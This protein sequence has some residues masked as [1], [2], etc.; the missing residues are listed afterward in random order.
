[1]AGHVARDQDHLY[2]LSGGG[3]MGAMAREYDW[4]RSPVG[5]PEQWPPSL[6]TTLSILFASRYPMFLW[7]GKELIQFYNDPYR[8]SLGELRHPAA[9]GQRGEECWTDIWNFIEPQIERVREGEST[10]SE[11]QLVPILRNGRMEEVFWTYSHS[12]VRVE[13]GEVEGILVVLTETTGQVLADRRM[14]SLAQLAAATRGAHSETEACEAA[15]AVLAEA[16]SDIP[17]LLIYLDDPQ[18]DTAR[19]VV[20]TVPGVGEP[21]APEEVH[22]DSSA[23]LWEIGAVM[24]AGE[25]RHLTDVTAR[26][27][28]LVAGPWPEPIEEA[29]V[30]P[31]IQPGQEA[32]SGVMVSGISPRIPFDQEYREYLNLVATTIATAVGESQ[33]FEAERRRAEALAELDQ[34]KT[35]FFSNVSHEF[36]TPLTLILGPVED[37]LADQEQVLAGRQR[38]RAELVHRNSLRLLKLVNTLLDFSRIEAGRLRAVYEKTDLAHFTT[39]L[40][41]IFRSTIERAGMEL[42]IQCDPIPEPVFVDRNLWEKIVLNLI[43][44][45][46][47]HTFEG[48]IGVFIRSVEGRIEL[49]VEDTGTGIPEAD[50]PHLFERFHR[51]EGAQG[52]TAEGTGIGLSLV[53]ELAHMHGGSVSVESTL[54]VGSCFRITIPAGAGHLDPEL[55]RETDDHPLPSGA[56]TP[57]LEEVRRWLPDDDSVPLAAA[58]PVLEATGPARPRGKVVLAED[59]ADMRDYLHRLLAEQDYEVVAVGNG[60]QALKA[61]RLHH[62]D[63]ILSDVMM[64]ELDG[65]ELLEAIRADADLASVRVILLSA[66]AGEEAR[67]EGISAGAD[68]YVVKPFS[69][70]ELIAQVG[71][72]VQIGQLHKSTNEKLTR[73]LMQAP[74]AVAV[75]SA[76]DFTHELANER[77]LEMIGRSEVIGKTI[78][79]VFPELPRDAPAIQLMHRVYDTGEVYIATEFPVKIDQ[80]GTGVPED[81]FFH[82]SLAPVFSETGEVTSLMTVAV[83]VT[84]HIESRRQVEGLL[85]EIR[86]LNESLEEQVAERTG[87]LR[88]AASRLTM[89]EQEERRRISQILHDNLQQLLC[90]VQLQLNRVRKDARAGKTEPILK[91]L[92]AMDEWLDESVRLTRQLTVDLSPPILK[93][94]GL[95]EALEWLFA[96]MKS[97]HGLQ[98]S[99]RAVH[100]FHIPD[101]D[102]R[103]LLFQIV[104]ELL[105]NVAKHSGTSRA[106][107]EMKD[108]EGGLEIHVRDKGRGFD[109]EQTGDVGAAGGFGLYSVRE[110]LALFGGTLSIK[111]AADYGT[112]STIRIQT[113]V[114]RG[115]AFKHQ[116]SA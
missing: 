101:E 102:M 69:A 90:G 48:H 45:A 114:E 27:G 50:L 42:R 76:P 88:D 31:I 107:V 116:R 34:A 80:K 28:E 54:G 77:Y 92:Q 94:E 71:A 5:P 66:R 73:L 78:Y 2:F 113:R 103:V 52:R 74:V 106:W 64:P 23:D 65:F 81:V 112:R 19:R 62:P 39:E 100:S 17:F 93:N 4:S 96:Q 26:C 108:I 9:F 91:K 37:A 21:A 25:A 14:Q 15:A 70:G 85:D 58:D 43:S 53:Q 51:V 68:A 11:N 72:Q 7:W 24:Q 95:K 109:S 3:E 46:F 60:E 61:A 13:S 22:P 89:A 111:S 30:L 63:V 1:M 75:W 18:A 105:F 87:Q 36:R 20:S 35:T 57:Y 115:P 56:S 110:R 12:P 6:K 44:N 8:P 82:F 98:V 79:E 67:I 41:S 86:Q 40:A 29:L 10:W 99:L 16:P 84:G 49:Q 32:A 97:L 83:D 104:R 55:V 38:E 47:K 33:A 59:N